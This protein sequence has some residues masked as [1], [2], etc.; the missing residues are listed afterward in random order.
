MMVQ[1][2][3]HKLLE[4]SFTNTF[5]YHGHKPYLKPYVVLCQIVTG[6]LVVALQQEVQVGST[7]SS[8]TSHT[9]T[10]FIE[11]RHIAA[12]FLIAQV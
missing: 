8:G 5:S 1:C 4:H 7:D 3:K 2:F 6:E 11:D 9:I 10:V 12:V